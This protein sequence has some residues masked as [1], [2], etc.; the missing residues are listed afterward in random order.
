MSQPID[1]ATV[2]VVPDLSDFGRLLKAE[3]DNA[4]RGVQAT[5]ATSFGRIE[6]MAAEA[7][8]EVGAA[9]QLG[10]EEAEGAFR[11]TSATA[12]REFAEIDASASATSAGISAKLGGALALVKT[13][14]IGA[15]VAAAA[16][17]G[18]LTAFGLKSAAALEQTTIGMSALLGGLDQ[19][20]SFI[21]ELQ[22]FS[23]ATPFEF[24]DVADASRRILAFGTSVGIARDQV[25]P[26]L[27]TIGD[28]VAVLGGTQ[29]NVQSVVRA[30]GQMASKGKVSQEE[31]LQLAEALPGFNINAAIAASQGLSVADTLDKITAGGVDAK[32]GIDAILKGMAQFPGAAGAMAAQAQTLSGVFSTFKDTVGIALTNAFQ[33]VIPE[34]KST[35]AELT[36]VIGGAIGEL[37]PA[38]G[39]GLSAILPL[40]G[41]VISAIVPILVPIIDALGPALDALGPALVPLGEAIGEVLVA[42][43]PSL[44][45][46][47]QFVA[48]L[49]ELAV[50]VLLLLAQIL[51]P[52]T[53]LLN[54]MTEAIAEFNKALMMIDWKGVGEAIATW[55]V[56]AWH[57][58]SDFFTKWAKGIF[59][60][61]AMLGAWFR[62]LLDTAW[63]NITETVDIIGS[64]PGRAIAALEGIGA[65]LVERGRQLIRG[66]WEGISQMGGWL[67]GQITGFIDRFVT[68]PV[69][70]ALGIHS[71]SQVMADEVGRQI[72]AGIEEGIRAGLPSLENLVAPAMVAV[73][74]NAAAGT[75][76]A[77][78]GVTINLNFY[79][80]QP[81][82]GDARSMATAAGDALLARLTRGSAIAMAGRTA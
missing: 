57:N 23:A 29:E 82:E 68:G 28:L 48:A 3:L 25:I 37:A 13:S 24:A 58:I 70:A 62:G 4:L 9:F 73:G 36:P 42:L 41:K 65:A 44:P 52:L 51:K 1:E 49:A 74:Q 35:L 12:R 6:A 79:G 81:T 61:G 38:L 75:G 32:T 69:K 40:L 20:N 71:P 47:G 67:W 72:P 17:L 10:G 2:L 78:G 34:I 80:G 31:V 14:L 55:T 77:V 16:G 8:A 18:A 53:P 7:G 56:D 33:P 63:Q 26:T 46:L 5:V 64:L 50:P 60:F 21:A 76:M 22:Q 27:T 15:G 19:A 66:L 45:L 54:F 39:R 11:E 43:G 30:F 59:D